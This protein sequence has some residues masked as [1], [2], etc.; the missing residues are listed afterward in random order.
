MLGRLVEVVSGQS[1]DEF[2]AERIF[3]PLG[4]TDTRWWVDGDDAGRLAALYAADPGHRRGVPL[5]RNRRQGAAQAEHAR[6][7]AAG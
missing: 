7:A 6:P 2:F 4:M 5:R 1:L 3:A